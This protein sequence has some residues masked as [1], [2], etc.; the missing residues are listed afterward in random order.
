MRT[1]L[2]ER[3]VTQAALRVIQTQPAIS[4]ALRNLRDALGEPLLVRGKTG[5]VPTEYGASLLD[6]A[7]SAL[8]DVD[9]VATP[10]G[11]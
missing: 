2:V 8:R 3:S 5:M 6:A 1:L 9:F 7:D 4:A 10:H 11:P